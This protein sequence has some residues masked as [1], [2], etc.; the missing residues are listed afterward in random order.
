MNKLKNSLKKKNYFKYKWTKHSNEKTEGGLM[1]KKHKE[2]KGSNTYIRQIDF[3]I[4][5]VKRDKE[6]HYITIKVT[7]KYNTCK[8]I[9]SQHRRT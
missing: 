4:K 8:Y 7:R 5:T 3:K 9:C 6:R 2:S 1:D